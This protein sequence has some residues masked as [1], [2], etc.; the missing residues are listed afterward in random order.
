MDLVTISQEL[1]KRFLEPLR[2]F[3]KRRIIIW[4]DEEKE[5]SEEIG[6]LELTN[7]KVICLTGNNN[8]AVKKTIAVD[9]PTQNFLLY[10]PISYEKVEDDWFLDVELYSEEFRADLIAIWMDEMGIPSSV[11]LRNLVKKYSK[12]LNAKARREGV[13]KLSDS[14]DSPMKLQLAIMASI[15]EAGRT[16]PIAIIKPVLKAG[17]S[18][19]DNYLYQEFVKYEATDLLWGMVS[20]ITGYNDV[21]HNRVSLQLT[22]Y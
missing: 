21:D 9:E 6:S 14:L 19:D 1:N 10:N 13:V 18:A 2:E 16:E 15:G 11:A 3:Y 7:A 20:S 4:Y 12:F 22:L 17:L 5:F 8:F